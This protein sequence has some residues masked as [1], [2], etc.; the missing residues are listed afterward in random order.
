MFEVCFKGHEQ[1]HYSGG[2]GCPV[3][4]ERDISAR[5]L[6][7]LQI[8]LEAAEAVIAERKDMQVEGSM[9]D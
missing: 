5:A 8:E 1:V 6:S 2:N 7:N 9:T 4:K 3:C